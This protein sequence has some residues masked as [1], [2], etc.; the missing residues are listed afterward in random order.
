MSYLWENIVT[1][2]ALIDFKL[3][4]E[5]NNAA[6]YIEQ[7]HCPSNNTTDFSGKN[8]S[9]DASKNTTVNSSYGGSSANTSVNSSHNSSVNSSRNITRYSSDGI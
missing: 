6:A 1:Q 8:A 2:G 4:N 5:I 3:V 7:T 9:V